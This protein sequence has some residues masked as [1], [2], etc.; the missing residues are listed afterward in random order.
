MTLAATQSCVQCRALL[1]ARGQPLVV[2]FVGS[3]LLDA[4]RRRARPIAAGVHVRLA[5]VFCVMRR[6]PLATR[7]QGSMLAV[8]S[9][10]LWV[11]TLRRLV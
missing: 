3:L 5:A 2:T 6:L 9:V 8:V 7:S 10:A 11:R 4:V 1:A